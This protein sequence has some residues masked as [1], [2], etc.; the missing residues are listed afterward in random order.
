EAVEADAPAVVQPVLQD[1]APAP[2]EAAKGEDPGTD[3]GE[4]LQN[5]ERYYGV[6]ASADEPNRAWFIAEAERPWY[7]EKAPPVPPGHLM[8]GAM[9]GDV[10]PWYL[11]TVSQTVFER[12]E[13]GGPSS[14]P[15]RI[16]FE[17]DGEGNAVAM[18][19]TNEDPI[20]EGRLERRGDLPEEWQ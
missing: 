16:E 20:T 9:F 3:F 11:R 2:S 18:R 7:A 14:D 8:I 1:A 17:L 19:F 10:A 6:Y 12:A 13:T 4:P 5:P 15:L